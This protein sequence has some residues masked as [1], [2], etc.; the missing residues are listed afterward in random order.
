MH[1][2]GCWLGSQATNKLRLRIVVFVLVQKPGDLS[3]QLGRGQQLAHRSGG[4]KELP[5]EFRGDGVPLHDNGSAEAS[6]NTLLF[7]GEG[8][9]AGW[10]F[11]RR[12][13]GPSSDPW[14]ILS[15]L[16]ASHSS[17]S[18]SELKLSLESLIFANLAWIARSFAEFAVFSCLRAI[19]FCGEHLRLHCRDR[20]MVQRVRFRELESCVIV[21]DVPYC[22]RPTFA[23]PGNCPKCECELS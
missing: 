19:L 9:V 16:S 3:S 8:D 23:E 10:L 6:K 18:A 1:G 22:D 2:L 11:I 20:R 21:I 14:S 15:K 13:I 4:V 5:L 17:L 12:F 7:R